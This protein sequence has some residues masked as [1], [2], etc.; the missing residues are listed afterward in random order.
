[1]KILAPSYAPA[2]TRHGWVART[3]GLVNSGPSLHVALFMLFLMVFAYTPPRWQDW[4]QNS[5]FDLTRAI[6]DQGTVRIDD[7]AENTGDY[8]VVDGH[9]YTDKA[10]G[11]SLLAVPVYAMTVHVLNPLGL[12]DITNRLGQSSAFS[13]TLTPGGEGIDENRVE[14]AVA[15]YIATLV[16]VSMPAA[17]M[18]V[19]LAMMVDRLAGCRTAGV[20]TALIIGLAT[21]VF[22]YS[23]AFYGHIPAAFCVVAAL[24]LLT[25][26]HSDEELGRRRLL[27]IG[28]LLGAA[29]IIEYPVALIA[30][31]VA[32][33]TVAKAG[34]RGAVFGALGALPMLAILAIYDLIAFGTVKPIGYEH[35]ALWQE[36]HSTGFM[37]ITYPHLDAIWGLTFSPF[38]GLFYYSPV[39]LLILAGFYL[40]TRSRRSW[41]PALVTGGGFVLLFLFVCS[42]VMWWGGFA[43]GPRYLV[44]AIP[45]LAIPL[46]Y[47]IA[48]VNG[49]APAARAVGMLAVAALGAISALAVWL[50]TF[51]TQNYPPDT[52]RDTISGYVWPAV[53]DGDVARNLGMAIELNGISSLVPL[54]I[55][56]GCGVLYLGARL[57]LSET[58]ST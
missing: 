52:V 1:M 19:L 28:A 9:I 23:Q 30:A 43:V 32:L 47:A 17:L 13:D 33:W 55:I 53:R 36:Q 58:V 42:S 4:N 3:R 8:A 54:I 37:S 40:A 25:L 44:P 34:I 6:V 15:L 51:A 38:R 10:P 31:P 16:T 29:I 50:T 39:L 11:L 41:T 26:A 24:A 20:L 48:W 18:L 45:L 57:A 35:S 46:G 14:I 56:T 49:S 12:S 27:A 22:A 21:P 2:S 7:Y 5:R